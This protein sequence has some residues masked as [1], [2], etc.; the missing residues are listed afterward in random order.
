M[1]LAWLPMATIKR[2]EA[3]DLPSLAVFSRKPVQINKNQPSVSNRHDSCHLTLSRSWQPAGA[4]KHEGSPAMWNALLRF[5]LRKLPLVAALFGMLVVM[6]GD[7]LS[8]Q[9]KDKDAQ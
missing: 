6:A 7:P 2:S 1:N 9:T 8:A 4:P 5:S 3:M